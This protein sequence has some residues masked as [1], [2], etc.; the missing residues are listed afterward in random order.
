MNFKK[1]YLNYK[2]VAMFFFVF[3]LIII[4]KYSKYIYVCVNGDISRIELEL[5][6]L[7]FKTMLAIVLPVFLLTFYIVYKYNE[8]NM[9]KHY[10]PNWSHSTFLEILIWIIP[11]CIVIFLAT[12]SYKSTHLLDPKKSLKSS[13][14][15]LFIDAIALDWRWLFIYP[16]YKIATINEIFLPK[17][18]AVNFNITSNSIMNSFFI[19]DLGSQIY[20]MAGMKTTLN[21]KT[22]K[23]GIYKGISANYSGKGFSNMKF[24]VHIVEN[25]SRLNAWIKEVKLSKNKL[26]F[27]KQFLKISKPSGNIF[28]QYFSYVDPLLFYK[29]INMIKY[30]V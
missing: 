15:V 27:K 9:D 28:I 13:N 26:I 11:I 2:K 20:A 29:I 23:T 1:N 5:I 18:T 10:I 19:P 17:N 30:Q 4:Y 21:L 6:L 25:F 8:I 14:P 12:L 3:F 24:N 16:Q 7:A 22:G